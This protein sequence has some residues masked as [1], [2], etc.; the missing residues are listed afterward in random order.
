MAAKERVERAELKPTQIKL[1]GKLFGGNEAAD[2]RAPIRNPRE[3]RINCCWDVDFQGLPRGEHVARTQKRSIALHACIT[4]A[5]QRER[6]LV[7]AVQ[8]R[9]FPI[10]A[11]AHQPRGNVERIAFVG[12]PAVHSLSE[13]FA[14]SV[15]IAGCEIFVITRKLAGVVH[16][17]SKLSRQDYGVEHDAEMIFVKLIEDD[18]WIRKY[19]GVP[20]ERAVLR[21]PSGRAET[22]AEINHCVAGKFFFTEGLCFS[23]DFFAAG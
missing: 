22:G 7:G 16:G 15:P 9:A 2:V 13:N 8:L 4:I 23:E 20:I 11:I 17:A 14:M 21:V 12:P 5:M 3:R 19:I 6:A 18:L 10:H 1:R